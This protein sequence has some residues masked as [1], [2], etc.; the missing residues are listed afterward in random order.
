MIMAPNDFVREFAE[1]FGSGFSI[2]LALLLMS[3]GIWVTTN[4]FSINTVVESGKQLR[5]SQY[6]TLCS[7]VD[8]MKRQLFVY[9]KDMADLKFI[10]GKNNEQI[11]EK[12]G[13][14]R[15]ALKR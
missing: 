9:Q 1:K 11:L 12:L 5:Q 4:I 10:V 15:G 7:D 2:A 3:W 14:I 8:E 13:E 6:A